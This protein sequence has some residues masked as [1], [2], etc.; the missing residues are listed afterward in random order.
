[1][2][3]CS[4]F[5]RGTQSA[6][7]CEPGL[8]PVSTNSACSL[9]TP[10]SPDPSLSVHLDLACLLGTSGLAHGLPR[11]RPDDLQCLPEGHAHAMSAA[12][13]VLHE[14]AQG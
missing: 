1:M 6:V 14:H 7:C 5:T 9:V 10:T 4:S 3:G 12:L 8:G 11:L 13:Q 2:A